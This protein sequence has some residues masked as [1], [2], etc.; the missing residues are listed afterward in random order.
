MTVPIGSSQPATIE[1]QTTSKEAWM[2]WVDLNSE[3]DL[4]EKAF[5]ELAF[6]V[7]GADSI[8][9]KE[10]RIFGWLN[11][12]RPVMISKPSIMGWGINAQHCAK[13]AF[14]GVTD[15]YE[16]FYQ[17]IR[18]IYRFGQT[19]PVDVHVIASDLEGAVLAN[20]RR[21]EADATAMAEQLSAKTRAAVMAHV[22]GSI[23]TTN[24]YAATKPLKRPTW[25]KS[26]Q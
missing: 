21:K 9:E 15:S 26:K 12:E 14:V 24:E 11:G 2:L 6:S 3:Q 23:S 13:M 22:F 19:R 8:E 10:R 17:S 7:R 20:L 16:A 4:L 5:G 25:L 18:R 1:R